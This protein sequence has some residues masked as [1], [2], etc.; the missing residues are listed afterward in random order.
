GKQIGTTTVDAKGSWSFTPTT[1]LANGSH[2]IT[3]TAT[4][5]A[6]N[7]SPAS[8]AVSFVVDTVAPGA[9]AIS[10]A[11]D[12][13]DPGKGTVSSGGSTNDPRPQL[14]G[15]AEPGSTVTIYDGSVAIGTAVTGSNGTWT[16][17]PSV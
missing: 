9:P 11:T 15:T 10:S 5:A 13:I 7:T 3:T 6:G 14:S 1:D 2:T 17:T 12:D 4:D 8:A 16:F